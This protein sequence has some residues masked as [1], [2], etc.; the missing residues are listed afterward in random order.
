LTKME[1]NNVGGDGE[2]GTHEINIRKT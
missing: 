1:V 2:S